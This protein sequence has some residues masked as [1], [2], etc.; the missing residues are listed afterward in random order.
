MKNY[1]NNLD[2]CQRCGMD[3]KEEAG[4]KYINK[5]RKNIEWPDLHLE[6]INLWNLPAQ[7]W[8][9]N[10]SLTEKD[11]NDKLKN[12]PEVDLL[13]IL[14]ICSE[15]IVDRFQDKIEERRDYFEQDLEDE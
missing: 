8:I 4:S 7:F 9:N 13:E 5:P 11:L 15:D 12:L 1:V 3:I 10:M 6:P 14:D 2:E